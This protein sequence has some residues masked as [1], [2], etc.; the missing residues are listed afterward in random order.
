MAVIFKNK[1]SR[2]GDSKQEENSINRCC[3][4]VMI[5]LLRDCLCSMFMMHKQFFKRK[6]NG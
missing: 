3:E 1:S 4:E 6:T 2:F 5:L